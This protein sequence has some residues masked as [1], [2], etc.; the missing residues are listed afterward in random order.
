MGCLE[1]ERALGRERGREA[2]RESLERRR[3]RKG[4]QAVAAAAA[5]DFVGMMIVWRC[6]VDSTTRLYQYM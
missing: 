5:M 4:R 6:I 1:G 2:S 3:E